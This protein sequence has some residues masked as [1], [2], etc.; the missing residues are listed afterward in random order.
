M[1]VALILDFPGGT[2]AQ[3]DL[4]VERMHLDGRMAPG[5]RLHLAGSYGSG[6]RVI[7]IWD[8]LE[9]FVRFRDDQIVPHAQAAGLGQP[10][11]RV[12]DVDEEKTGS[13]A[14]TAFVQCVFLP[15]ID[16]EAFRAADRKI[17]PS[18]ASPPEITFHVN[19]PHEGGW[20]VLDG[21]TSQ[22]ARD[23]FM[24]ST[25]RVVMQDAPLTGPPRFEDM[26]VEASLRE[27][28]ATAA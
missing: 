21:W 5:G 25:V 2:K 20:L 4:V 23:Q 24:E 17:L 18:G 13:G 22:A 1:T 6:W 8:D 9:R 10:N 14:P 16:R 19:G 3:Y 7:D 27:A 26:V 15:G 11:V 28:A 12:L